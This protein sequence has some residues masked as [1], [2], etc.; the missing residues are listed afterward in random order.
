METNETQAA[1]TEEA[2]P[3]KRSTRKSAAEK[4]APSADSVFVQYQNTET[5][6]NALLEQA[7]ASFRETKKR[8]KI[9]ELKL[10]VKPEERAAYYV[11]NGTFEGKLD[12]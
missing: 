6:V 1:M 10:Y 4:T 12:F 5:D 9:T 11:I 7:R 2:A 3:K 8:T